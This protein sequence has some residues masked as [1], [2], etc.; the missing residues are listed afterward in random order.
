MQD[1]VSYKVCGLDHPQPEGTGWNES[2]LWYVYFRR[3]FA[4]KASEDK[5]INNIFEKIDLNKAIK[6]SVGTGIID[7]LSVN[8]DTHLISA[9]LVYSP[10]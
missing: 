8:I 2:P 10:K 3:L 9:T 7:S 5:E 6:T 1:C 4:K